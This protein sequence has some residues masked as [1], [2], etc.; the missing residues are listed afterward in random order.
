VSFP[1][2]FGAPEVSVQNP[3]A[4]PWDS[5]VQEGNPRA[6]GIVN[7]E[8]AFSLTEEEIVTQISAAQTESEQARG[9]LESKWWLWE[10]LYRLRWQGSDKQDW[11]AD[12]IVPEVRHKIQTLKSL[13]QSALV[14]PER[15][16]ILVKESTL[17]GDEGIRFIEAWMQLAIRQSK[18][19][20]ALLHVLEEAFLF[21]TGVM[22]IHIESEVKLRPGVEMR[23]VYA[24]PQMAMQAAMAGMETMRPVVTA[25]PDVLSRMKCE[26]VHLRSMF[27]DPKY[28]FGKGRYTIERFETDREVLEE[29]VRLGIYDSLDDIGEGMRDTKLST[30]ERSELADAASSIRKRDVIDEYT[31]NLYKDGELACKNWVVS[32]ANERKIV[33]IGPNPIWS[34][35]S[36]YVSCTPLPYAGRPWGESMIEADAIVEMETKTLLD[37]MLDDVKY[38]V[39]G[40]FTIDRSKSND[41]EPVNSIEPGRMYDGEGQFLNKLTFPSNGNGAWPMITHLQGIGD[42]STM[43]NEFAAG[44]PSSRG[45]PSATEVQSKTQSA[46]GH[47]HNVARMLEEEFVEPALQLIFEYLMQFGSD[48]DPELEELAKDYGGAQALMD[49]VQ[50]FRLL[51]V[52]FRIQ[53]RGISM[54]AGR[55][56]L[57][58]KLMQLMQMGQQMNMPPADPLK[59]WFTMIGSMGFS[60]EQI[61]YTSG[62]EQYAAFQ[63]AQ[64]QAQQEGQGGA[65]GPQGGSA[66]TPPPE[67]APSAGQGAPPSPENLAQMTAV[68]PPPMV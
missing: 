52:P 56:A 46:T 33:R 22:K 24:D 26:R 10:D 38:S 18:F 30:W 68:P 13:L 48:M 6:V 36:R 67:M 7:E 49:P 14:D 28:E 25:L 37:L 61:G 57:W 51:D 23:P 8:L 47:I 43:V 54:L 44:T 62:P 42:K 58:Q 4:S 41:I 12:I 55:E 29:Y 31:G 66:G 34:G 9:P 27:P 21:G 63:Q 3:T 2:L 39:L 16:F 65:P 59:G 64:Q 11:Q 32:V 20:P 60:P 35:R 45:R 50:R 53:V 17:F 19:L 40:A 1:D 5:M 15:F